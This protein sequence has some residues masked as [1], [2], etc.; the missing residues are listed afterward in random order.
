MN[1]LWFC[2]S[3]SFTILA[4]SQQGKSSPGPGQPKPLPQQRPQVNNSPRQKGGS[5]EGSSS[6]LGECGH[7]SHSSAFGGPQAPLRGNSG[8]RGALASTP[9]PDHRR[10]ISGA[11]NTAPSTPTRLSVPPDPAVLS[12]PSDLPGRKGTLKSRFYSPKGA[13]WNRACELGAGEVPPPPAPSI[14]RPGPA[15]PPPG[16]RASLGLGSHQLPPSPGSPA[17]AAS[18]VTQPFTAVGF[19]AVTT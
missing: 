3:V 11:S 10:P 17:P 2:T 6:S 7:C 15:R 8:P 9:C 16:P 12:R 18:P 1:S 19:C 14:P 5:G 4:H 13:W